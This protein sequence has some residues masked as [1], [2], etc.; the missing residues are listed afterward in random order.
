MKAQVKQHNGTPTLFLDDKPVY[1]NI[2]LFGGWNPAGIDATLAAIRRFAGNGIHI[3]SL[4]AVSSEWNAP[5]SGA[6]SG[7]NGKYDFAEGAP[8]LQRVLEADP[9]ALFLLRTN[10][11]THWQSPKWLNALQPDDVE[12][13][14]DGSRWGASL[15]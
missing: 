9:E 10:F 7:G 11:E 4:D 14:S 13:L 12:V 3:Y 5:P 1:A 2:H 6:P 15:A 8:A